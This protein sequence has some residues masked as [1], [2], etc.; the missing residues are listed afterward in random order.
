MATATS[1]PTQPKPPKKGSPG[2]SI[3]TQL[4]VGVAKLG[5]VLIEQSLQS[6]HVDPVRLPQLLVANFSKPPLPISVRKF[7]GGVGTISEGKRLA[8]DD[9]N[10][11]LDRNR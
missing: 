5:L 9:S 4:A 6:V 11:D 10:G 1:H 7:L 3:N 2:R 8:E